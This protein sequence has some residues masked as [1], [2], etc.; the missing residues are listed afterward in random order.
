MTHKDKIIW[1]E[2]TRRKKLFHNSENWEDI[3]L[4]GLFNWG[5][6]SHLLKKGE[7]KTTMCKENK[8]IWVTP[9]KEAYH[10]HI[11]PLLIFS[12]DELEQMAGWKKG[13]YSY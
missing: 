8:T 5:M 3:K 13:I 9:S 2:M 7:L 10:K 12:N 4:W 1:A 6:V 11:E